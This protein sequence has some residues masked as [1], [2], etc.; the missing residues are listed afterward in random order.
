MQKTKIFFSLILLTVQTL[1]S[2]TVD[3]DLSRAM[4]AYNQEKYSVALSMFEDII[5]N[6]NVTELNSE[7]AEYYR[8]D[9]FL[10]LDMNSAA[11]PAFESFIE[12]YPL[13][14]FRSLALYKLG[15]L[16][17]GEEQYS[18]SAEKFITLT[19]EYPKGEYTGN[20]Y[21]W[22][23]EAF[24]ANN[25]FDKA[26]QFL[27]D[28]YNSKSIVYADYC[29]FALSKVYERREKYRKAVD[30]Y[31]ELLSSH[32]N[33]DLAPLAQL[34]IGICHFKLKD[35]NSAVLELSD[36][37]ITVLP[38]R[39]KY[40]ANYILAD[41]F[42]RLKEYDNAQRTYKQILTRA[43][44]E[45]KDQIQYGLGWVNFQL[46]KYDDAFQIFSS[47]ANSNNDTLAASSLYW[48][49]E[50]KRYGG[51]VDVAMNRLERYL[52]TYPRHY[53]APTAQ[54]NIAIIYFQ[55]ENYSRAEEYLLSVIQ[56][57]EEDIKSKAYNLLGEISLLHKDFESAR[58]YFFRAADLSQMGSD[59][60]NRSKLGLGVAYYFEGNYQDVIDI[61]N[62]VNSRYQSF[63]KAK[64][65]F[66]LA[67]SHFALS[68][69]ESA[70]RHYL[71]VGNDDKEVA[72]QALYGKAYTYYNL[73][74]FSNAAYYF[75]EY[76]K[77]Y[78]K[79]KKYTDAKLRMADSYYGMK[80][81]ERAS[82]IYNSLFNRERRNVDDDAA[83]YQYG[84]A[85]FKSG[86]KEQ[87]IREFESIQ[88]RFHRSKYRDDSQYIIGWIYF[89]HGEFEKAIEGFKAL[90]E[91]Y[92]SSP[93]RPI[94]YYSI[95]DSYFNLARY[96]SAIVSYRKILN[97]FP[98]SKYVYDAI[99]GI[100]YCYVA[101]DEP[102]KAVELVDRF[103]S[104]NPDYEFSDQVLF[105][106]GEIYY[107]LGEYDKSQN[108]YKQFIATFPNSKLI[109]NAYFWIGKCKQIT[110]NENEALENFNLVYK[111][112]PTSEYGVSA[113]LEMG[114]IKSDKGLNDEAHQLYTD[115]ISKLDGDKRLPELIFNKGVVEVAKGDIEQAY[116]TFNGLVQSYA[117]SIFTEQA[118]IELGVLELN[119]GD[120][121]D[122]QLLFNEVGEK[123]TDDLG[124]KAQYYYGLS[125][126]KQESYYEA[127]TV[128]VRVRSVYPGYDEWY[129]KSLIGLGDCYTILGDKKEAREM[130]RAVLKRH[131]NDEYSK[132]VKNKMKKL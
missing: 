125:L 97:E 89:Q 107:S 99:N 115:A 38:E 47:L 105:K 15:I 71:R 65:N 34:R 3:I 49:A 70:L 106:K 94:A 82:E 83:Y 46:Q 8:A 117:E 131:T 75:G 16:L 1:V 116:K 40:Q 4:D 44:D 132:E 36:S 33:S 58:E 55:K 2:Q 128:F 63:E 59:L 112:Y 108:G 118:K 127:I 29:L 17:F 18:K 45:D 91:K 53:L 60:S 23:G 64:V 73:K 79:D 39:E 72:K 90:Y 5:R 95:G 10:A 92:P 93:L 62:E 35:Y 120:Y 129:T 61:L 130:Y 68:N 121:S 80:D 30:Y 69:Y 14:K 42:F 32:W 54:F 50:C 104:S 111:D 86:K 20:A 109:P 87:A 78:G 126:M 98:K 21:Y 122:A 84:Q 119:S 19:R 51:D 76:A 123:R 43:D 52:E 48:S 31:D 113:V 57:S 11:I 88:R 9:C 124:A 96:D 110:G 22:L 56:I 7:V 27:L 28:A 74:D 103:I 81:F 41:S 66:Y 67:E 102:G 25:E 101:E 77:Q 12:T 13:S 100:Q 37:L 85:L 114:K 26:E 24:A 6:S